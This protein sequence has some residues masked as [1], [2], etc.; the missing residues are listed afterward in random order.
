MPEQ[1]EHNFTSFVSG[2]INSGE[3]E[4]T[5][6]QQFFLRMHNNTHTQRQQGRE[7][8]KESEWSDTGGEKKAILITNSSE[9]WREVSVQTRSNWPRRQ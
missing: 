8:A 7:G 4:G 2:G 6:R 9:Q 5:T 3:I 1:L